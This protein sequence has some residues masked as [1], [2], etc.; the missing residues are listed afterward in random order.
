MAKKKEVK[1]SG[2]TKGSDTTVDRNAEGMM[3]QK[4]E[5]EAGTVKQ[6]QH[7]TSGFYMFTPDQWHFLEEYA[8]DLDQKRAAKSLGLKPRTI[9][10]WMSQEKF[11]AEI[12]EIHEVYR[13]NVKMTA[14]NS[15][16]RLLKML[17]KMEKDY[18]TLE[19]KDRAKMAAPISKMIDSY[20]KATGQYGDGRGGSD[21][22]VVI[23]IDLG[24]NDAGKTINGK[25]EI[26]D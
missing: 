5:Y 17:N 16:H 8:K 4:Y 2:G 3:I 1:R 21:T 26:I 14:E 15:G 24:D 9:E 12:M 25:A 13:A 6:G 7:D 10:Q 19:I 20:L 18:D 23:N 22:Q 11:Q